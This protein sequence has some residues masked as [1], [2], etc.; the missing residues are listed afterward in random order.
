MINLSKMI[1]KPK[2]TVNN[3][4]KGFEQGLKTSAISGLALSL[5]ISL[6]LIYLNLITLTQTLPIATTGILIGLIGPAMSA[7]SVHPLI[8]YFNGKNYEHTYK[9]FAFLTPHSLIGS[10][11]GINILGLPALFALQINALKQVHELEWGKAILAATMPGIG[12]TIIGIAVLL[13]IQ[14]YTPFL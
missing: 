7:V 1:K 9:C 2:E 6:Q 12:L 8:Y 10:I 4:K 14:I 5:I 13:G 3:S 11:P